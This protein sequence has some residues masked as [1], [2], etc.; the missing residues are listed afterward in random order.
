MLLALVLAFFAAVP[1]IAQPLAIA[2]DGLECWPSDGYPVLSGTLSPPDEARTLR[3]YF[4]SEN[5]PDFYFV[6]ATIQPDGRLEAVL[7]LAAPDT[8]RVVYYLEAVGRSFETARTREWLPEVSESDDCRRRDPM[9]ALFPDQLP[10]I[11]VTAVSA[12]AP[13]F[14]PGFLTAGVLAAGAGAGG[15]GA[16]AVV[17]IVAGGVV[18]GV[19]IANG[20]SGNTSSA[21]TSVLASQPSTSIPGGS[22]STAP[23]T[24]TVPSSQPPTTSS[25]TTTAPGGSTTTTAISTSTTTTTPTTSTVPVTTT[26]TS[27]PSTTSIVPTTTTVVPTTT[28]SP[29]GADMS[30]TLSA[31]SSVG[32]ARPIRYSV[33]VRNNG[34]SGATGVRM[35]V[36]LPLSVTFRNSS[37]GYCSGG[38]GSVVCDLGSMASGGSATIQITVLTLQLGSVT[39]TANVGAN[40]PDPVPGNNTDSKTTNVTLFVRESSPGFVR[41]G[42]RLNAPHA[43]GGD[44]GEVVVDSTLSG[45]DDTAPIELP[46]SAEPGEHVVEAVLTRS[47]GRRGTW[48]F[49]LQPPPGVEVA[50]IEVHSG[51][52]AA[53]EPRAVSFHAG[54][55]VGERLRFRYRIE[56][57][58]DR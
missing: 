47:T 51:E 36:S 25:N 10:K 48:R 29:P 23:A 58:E 17:G 49:E 40:E 45:I 33:L 35:T 55:G 57:R 16:T 1:A 20:A 38:F 54:G 18:G 26:T 3:V 52:L 28:S 8:E 6:D 30:V 7:P 14:P 21:T 22:T 12:G 43:V 50:A 34:P 24:T 53:S 42:I 2:H 32:L 46:V 31:P 41:L 13:A 15:I 19:V 11:V 56:A 5:Y 4:R 27:A 39:A 9:L 37:V 44:R